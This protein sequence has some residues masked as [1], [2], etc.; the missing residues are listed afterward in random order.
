MTAN[1]FE[2]TTSIS[3]KKLTRDTPAQSEAGTPD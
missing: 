3:L 2:E 1:G